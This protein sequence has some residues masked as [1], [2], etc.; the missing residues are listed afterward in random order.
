MA[1]ADSPARDW[2][3]EERA[4]DGAGPQRRPAARRDPGPAGGR[5]SGRQRPPRMSGTSK[6]GRAQQT[7]DGST[8]WTRIGEVVQEAPKIN[9]GLEAAI[10]LK[11]AHGGFGR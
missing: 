7:G 11:T 9:A 3:R 1:S 4:A 10:R 5:R 2:G 8:P 6:H